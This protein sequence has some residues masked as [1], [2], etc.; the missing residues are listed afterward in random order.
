MVII[1][2]G[3][4][5]PAVGGGYSYVADLKNESEWVVTVSVLWAQVQPASSPG[6]RE[7]GASIGEW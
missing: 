3:G 4:M 6:P 7:G 1:M 2:E 5:M